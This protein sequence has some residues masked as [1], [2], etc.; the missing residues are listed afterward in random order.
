[1]NPH[2]NRLRPIH[3]KTDLTRALLTERPS[4]STYTMIEEPFEQMPDRPQP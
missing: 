1:M 3:L 4:G 2:A